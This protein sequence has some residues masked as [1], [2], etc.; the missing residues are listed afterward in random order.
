M[1]VEDA[2]AGGGGG[3]LRL[4]GGVGQVEADAVVEQDG[5]AVEPGQGEQ[6]VEQDPVGGIGGGPVGPAVGAPEPVPGGE[7]VLVHDRAHPAH[8]VR[9][10]GHLGPLVPGTGEGPVHG[11]QGERAAAGEQ[12]GLPGEGGRG[13]VVEGVEGLGRIDDETYAGPGGGRPDGGVGRPAGSLRGALALALALGPGPGRDRHQDRVGRGGCVGR[14]GR[15]R[16]GRRGRPA[17]WTGRVRRRRQFGEAGQESRVRVALASARGGAPGL[18]GAHR[19]RGHAD[20]R[21]DLIECQFRSF[22]QSSALVRG[23]QALDASC[24]AALPATRQP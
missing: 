21:R 12:V 24:H 8:R 18:P 17:R 4:G 20:R 19:R 6:R 9:V 10:G 16:R 2:V 5:A 1:R 22:A 11:L 7:R 14:G 15:V 3:G 23:G 13:Q